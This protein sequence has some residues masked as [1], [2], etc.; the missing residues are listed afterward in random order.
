MSNKMID[1]MW[2]CPICNAKDT[3]TL[4]RVGGFFESSDG[5]N[6]GRYHCVN[7]HYYIK[8]GCKE[9]NSNTQKV[10]RKL[11]SE[12]FFESKELQLF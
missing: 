8:T 2:D 3:V 12:G 4:V 7:T 6:K 10:R 9:C 11:I 5:T 1:E